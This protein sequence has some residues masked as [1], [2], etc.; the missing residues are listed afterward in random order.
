MARVLIL[1]DEADLVVLYRETLERIGHVVWGAYADPREALARVDEG[2]STP[3]V[4]LLDERLG[5]LSGSYY[6]PELKKA[7]PRARIILATA[8]PEV[9]ESAVLLGA[10]LAKQKPFSLKELSLM[11]SPQ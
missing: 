10:D 11:I 7:F 3:E 6:I 5:H 1:E 8:D 9:A 4:I 2:G